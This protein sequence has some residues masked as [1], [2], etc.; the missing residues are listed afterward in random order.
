MQPDS[1]QQFPEVEIGFSIISNVTKLFHFGSVKPLLTHWSFAVNLL[2]FEDLI[3]LPIERSTSLIPS[4]KG[5]KLF[6]TLFFFREA[7]FFSGS[8]TI[9]L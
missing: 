2:S 8:K 7:K 9:N 4:F 6:H 3:L 1:F 5:R